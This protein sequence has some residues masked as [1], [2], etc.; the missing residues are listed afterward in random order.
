M[1]ELSQVCST[2]YQS[3]AIEGANSFFCRDKIKCVNKGA[4]VTCKTCAKKNRSCQFS[5]HGSSNIGGGGKGT[6]AEDPLDAP[7]LTKKVWDEVYDIFELHYSAEMPFLH[8]LTFK[9]LMCRTSPPK[10]P[11]VAPTD[12]QNKRLLLLAFLALTAR[13]HPGLIAYHLRHRRDAS[14]YYAEAVKTAIGPRGYL[15][16]RPSIYNIQ[17]LLMLGLYEW[18]QARGLSAWIVISTA[19]RLAQ[20]TGLPYEDPDEKRTLDSSAPQKQVEKGAKKINAKEV[21][22]R[23]LWSCF[24]MD[25][26]LSV[27]KQRPTMISLNQLKVQ[28]PCSD[29]EFLFVHNVR[30]CFLDKP[31]Q[32]HGNIQDGALIWYVRMVEIFDRVSEWS[33]AGGRRTEISPPWNSSSQFY[34]LRQELEHFRLALPS[35][36]TLT[37]TN[38]SAHIKKRKATTYASMHA[39]YSLCRMVLHRE[40]IPFIP[41]RCEKPQGPLDEPI[42]PEN[43]YPVPKGFW[44]DSASEIFKAARDIVGIVATCQGR[45]ALPESP[46]IGFAIWQAAFVCL[47]AFHFPHMDVDKYLHLGSD[48]NNDDFR[49]NC[50]ADVTV[51]ILGKMVPRLKMANGYLKT[52]HKMHE[53]FSDVKTEIWPAG[54][55]LEEYKSFEKDLTEFGSLDTDVNPASDSSESFDETY[56]GYNGCGSVD[57]DEMHGI[58]AALQ[59]I[60]VDFADEHDDLTAE[61]GYRDLYNPSHPQSSSAPNFNPPGLFE[62]SESTLEINFPYL[63]SQSYLNPGQHDFLPVSVP[64]GHYIP[65][66]APPNGQGEPQQWQEANPTWMV[67]QEGNNA[68][69]YY[70]DGTESGYTETQFH[71]LPDDMQSFENQSFPHIHGLWSGPDTLMAEQRGFSL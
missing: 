41:L 12:I 3:L 47:Y 13:F 52:F 59:L 51:R 29:D 39:L 45:N 1:C 15:S 53:Y 14:E 5:P 70:G 9:Y 16:T 50:Y 69:T 18:G 23:T 24:I 4:T 61:L 33:F 56:P 26:A 63:Q 21:R 57:R 30:T 55:G 17:A 35:N 7:V 62:P 40:Y 32:S 49:S 60:A 65:T 64:A 38:L 67:H 19:T 31:F 28:L 6:R 66:T 54:G 34:K 48:Q 43:E 71:I 68:S 27:G 2:F 25:R 58:E 36:L 10:D 37:D 8:P 46:Q 11:S 22:R 44:E 42:F 20:A